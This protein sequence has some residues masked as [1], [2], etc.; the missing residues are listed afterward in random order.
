MKTVCGTSPDKDQWDTTQSLWW[1]SSVSQTVPV[2]VKHLKAL[3]MSS[4]TDSNQCLGISIL[5]RILL[6][7]KLLKRFFLS[8]LEPLSSVVSFIWSSS[9]YAVDQ[10]FT[11][12][13]S[14]WF[15]V[16]ATVDGC[17]TLTAWEWTQQISTNHTTNTDHTPSGVSLVSCSVA[18]AA[19]SPILES[20]LTLW[21]APL[22]S[23][24]EPHKCLWFHHFSLS[25]SCHGLLPGLWF[26]FISFPLVHWNKELTSPSF[27]R[28]KEQR[29]LTICSFTP[30]LD[31][32]G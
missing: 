27:P 12:V 31:T 32:S 11:S 3:W 22:N 17:Y 29:K 2:W 23:L 26:P 10:L 16:L 30:Y 5:L 20:E 14:A 25:S 15:L 1:A 24:E 7:F 21:N 13:F 4:I 9:D 8:P 28:S 19:I 6:I 18:F